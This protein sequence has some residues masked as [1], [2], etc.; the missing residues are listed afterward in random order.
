MTFTI[1]SLASPV[2]CGSYTTTILT[3]PLPNDLTATIANN[4]LSIS[5]SGSSALT[6]STVQFKVV[7]DQ[8]AFVPIFSTSTLV[9]VNAC[10]LTAI[11]TSTLPPTAYYAI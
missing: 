7:N 1:L 6:A 8:F 4:Q 11:Q 9:T 10:V 3:S 5:A 2:E